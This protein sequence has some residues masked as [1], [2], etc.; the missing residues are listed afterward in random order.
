[1]NEKDPKSVIAAL[2]EQLRSLRPDFESIG[3]HIDGYSGGSPEG[4]IWQYQFRKYWSIPPDRAS[5]AVHLSWSDWP[6]GGLV[7]LVR[8]ADIFRQG[9][10]SSFKDKR[11]A[12][13]SLSDF[14][15]KG[16][17]EIVEDEIDKA[18]LI[19]ERATNQ[20]LHSDG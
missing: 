6:N 2:N 13:F 14:I 9:Q 10:I 11:G 17:R 20:T 8:L 4:P 1:M 18:Q 16:V 19:L 7:H 15:M 12:V 5:A 3:L